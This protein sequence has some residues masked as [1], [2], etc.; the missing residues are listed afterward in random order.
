MFYDL[1]SEPDDEPTTQN[2][3]AQAVR[4]ELDRLCKELA[5]ANP[6]ACDLRAFWL[7]I[8][9]HA[10]EGAELARIQAMD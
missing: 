4:D 8:Q 9:A 6:D 5:Q 3:L 7:D 1:A 10:A 2:G